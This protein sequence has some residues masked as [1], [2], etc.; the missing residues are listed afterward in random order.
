MTPETNPADKALSESLAF[1]GAINASVT[2]ELNN[3]LG[4]IEQISGLLEDLAANPDNLPTSEDLESIS[5]RI[6]KQTVRGTVLVKRLNSFAHSG[7]HA[8]SEFSLSDA[9]ENLIALMIRLAQMKRIELT[10]SLPPDDVLVRSNMFSILQVVFLIIKKMISFT[11]RDTSIELQLLERD[12][13][14]VVTIEAQ[15]N[16]NAAV[17]SEEKQLKILVTDLSGTIEERVDTERIRVMFSI[18]TVG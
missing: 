12:N 14:A 7:D 11:V 16:E 5:S 10:L 18:P 9:I 1:F 15:H 6:N 2:H 17:L 8:I 4:T 13:Q 3:V